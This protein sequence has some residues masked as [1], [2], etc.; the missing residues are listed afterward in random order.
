M[1]AIA[2]L[3][4]AIDAD[5]AESADAGVARRPVQVIGVAIDDAAGEDRLSFIVVDNEGRGRLIP[6]SRLTFTDDAVMPPKYG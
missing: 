6:A 4:A 1:T 3:P 2:T 5:I